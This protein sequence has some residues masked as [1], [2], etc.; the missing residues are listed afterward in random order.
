MLR[1]RGFKVCRRCEAIFH[2]AHRRNKISLRR[3][4]STGERDL[5]VLRVTLVSVELMFGKRDDASVRVRLR[6]RE[7][8][9][10]NTY[11]V[12]ATYEPFGLS[13]PT[14]GNAVFVSVALKG[15]R[16]NKKKKNFN[17]APG[18]PADNVNG[19]YRSRDTTR[20]RRRRSI[21]RPVFKERRLSDHQ[22]R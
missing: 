19:Y 17:S 3:T 15:R 14:R 10:A 2:R 1:R 8:R 12:S 20:D 16:R 4:S 7:H 21:V 13:T 9:A 18:Q 11:V 22:T 6:T 5:S